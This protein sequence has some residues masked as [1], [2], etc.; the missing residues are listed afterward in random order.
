MEGLGGAIFQRVVWALLKTNRQKKCFFEKGGNRA[1]DGIR[2]GVG[3][4]GGGWGGGWGGGGGG[5]G[6]EF[7]AKT[8]VRSFAYIISTFRGNLRKTAVNSPSFIR[9][10]MKMPRLRGVVLLRSFHVEK[11]RVKG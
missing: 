5:G 6:G 11:A 10:E 4:G 9:G 3:G 2:P 7:V 1:G 8:N